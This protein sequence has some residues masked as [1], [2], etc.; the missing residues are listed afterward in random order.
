MSWCQGK[1]PNGYKC[2][3]P[4]VFAVYL[5]PPDAEDTCGRHLAQ[6]VTARVQA[7]EVKFVKVTHLRAVPALGDNA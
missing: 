3:N 7:G 2:G 1:S 4:A 5:E 6:V